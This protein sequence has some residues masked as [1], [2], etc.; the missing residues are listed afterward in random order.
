VA[1]QVVL[2]GL[3]GN[4]GQPAASRMKR[5]SFE[6]EFAGPA[7]VQAVASSQL[8]DPKTGQPLARVTQRCRLWTGRPVVE[9]DVTV[10]ELDS[11][12]SATAA[13]ADPW[14]RHLACRW[15]W[16]DATSTLRRL[17]FLSPETTEAE[18]PETP[19]AIDVSMRRQR[20]A[21]VFGGL[22]YHKRTGGR[23]LDTLLVAA[24]ETGREFNLAV[25]LDSEHPHR[26]A[27][28]FVTPAIVV[29]TDAG[30]PP[31]G[32]RGWLM[33]TDSQA[34]AVTHVGF[35]HETYDERGW[36]LDVHLVE[37]AGYHARCRLRFFR[38]P[39]WAR[40]YDLQ[41]EAIGDL[42]VEGD[43]VWVDLMAGE[44]FRLV[45]AFG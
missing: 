12:W 10:S 23:M 20:T 24:S 34:V 21:L 25:V 39:T 13:G 17:A 27:Q 26:P 2:T 11:S 15:A 33:R 43:G 14:S 42:S 36:G 3:V 4:D 30:P 44:L 7:V 19:D 38:N 9:L 18:R 40:Q 6:V 22:P 37:T 8:L 45:V 29:E 35:L 5:L 32:D 16:P 1:Q 41:G 31:L 28:D